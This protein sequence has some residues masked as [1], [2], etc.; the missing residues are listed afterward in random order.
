MLGEVRTGSRT[1]WASIALMVA[2]IAAI[3][4]P[5]A[6]AAKKRP[7]PV[8][9]PLAVTTATG[10][11]S[12]SA[13]D[14]PPKVAELSAIA[15]CPS[16]TV[17]I[18]GGFV[19][20]VVSE[21]A[22]ESRFP[23]VTES[24]RVGETQ[25]LTRAGVAFGSAA[26]SSQDLTT[27]VYCMPRKGT[28]AD[29]V[30][31]NNIGANT[32]DSA[33]FSAACPGSSRLLSGGFSGASSA[34]PPT[35]VFATESA[36]AGNAWS[37]HMSRVGDAT[38]TQVVGHA[39]CYT[40]PKAKKKKKKSTRASVAKKRKRRR[41]TGPSPLSVIPAAGSLGTTVFSTASLTTGPC[42]GPLRPVSGGFSAPPA[43][44]TSGAF[45]V[46]A[47]LAGR[48]WTTTF[49]QGGFPAPSDLPLTAFNDCA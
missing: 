24:V 48:A 42:A 37:V 27:E 8:R 9:V 22:N 40:P 36:P 38:P 20:S 2:A 3:A 13:P 7:K 45:V 18:G 46:E 10:S 5:S 44:A 35:F 16:G 4:V 47:R 34:S 19:G 30:T 17:A 29:V 49:V 14:T 6:S 21:P 11:A 1:H 26:T 23:A 25:W 33:N 28:I 15:T 43:A 12:V 32:T 39:Y 41:I 31:Q